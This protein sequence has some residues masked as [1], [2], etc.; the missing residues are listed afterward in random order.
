M[1][2]DRVSLTIICVRCG[3]TQVISVP[4]ERGIR[5]GRYPW[6]CFDCQGSWWTGRS[7]EP[8]KQEEK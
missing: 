2:G 5:P 8:S 6:A 4:K 7:S 3:R 1:N